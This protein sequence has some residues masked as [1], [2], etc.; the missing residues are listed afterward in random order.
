MPRGV[1][2][3]DA[4]ELQSRLWTPA[5]MTADG[6]SWLD[7]GHPQ[8]RTLSSGTITQIDDVWRRSSY[9]GQGNTSLAPAVSA[10]NGR[11][12]ANF[13]KTN[14][15]MLEY[16]TATAVMGNS[17]TMAICCAINAAGTNARPITFIRAA[18][19]ND[20][21]NT[22]SVALIQR[23]AANSVETYH[24]NAR[25]CST[26]IV[27]GAT[28]VFVVESDGT[29]VRH[30]LNGAAGG[31]GTWGTLALGTGQFGIG[32]YS[33]GGAAT[34]YQGLW[35][36]MVAVRVCATH[37]RQRLE[38]YLAHRWGLAEKLAG[39]HPYRNAPPLIGA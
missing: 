21:D 35:G 11:R 25:R 12:A 20:Y 33:S 34:N 29:N 37:V 7:S 31:S 10:I 39:T 22:A 5:V 13:D 18:G 19:G 1:S 30:F 16:Y 15:V 3:Y 9:V 8:R 6:A 24:N 17:F 38:G 32:C 27:D 23:Y 28:M 2:R 36:E 4:A 14:G 26:T